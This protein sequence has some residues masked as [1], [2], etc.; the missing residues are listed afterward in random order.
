VFPASRLKDDLEALAFLLDEFIAK[1]VSV[2]LVSTGFVHYRMRDA[3]EMGM[4][5]LYM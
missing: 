1:R 3:S 2:R 5:Q 4:A